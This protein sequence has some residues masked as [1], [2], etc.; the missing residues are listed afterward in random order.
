MQN[1][2]FLSDDNNAV[3]LILFPNRKIKWAQLLFHEIRLLF[4]AIGLLRL[5]KVLNREQLLRRNHP[6]NR[7]YMHLWF[8]GIRSDQGGKGIGG[9]ILRELI[10]KSERDKISIIVE[11][12]ELPSYYSKFG[13]KT[14]SYLK[15]FVLNYH[16][17]EFNPN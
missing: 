4:E 10:K 7:D 3:V 14:F 13:F 6:K 8:M 11:T 1:G 17:M 16:I 12:V 15:D 9:E 5:I 2:A